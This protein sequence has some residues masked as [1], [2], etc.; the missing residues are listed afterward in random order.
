MIAISGPKGSG[1]DTVGQIIQQ[2]TPQ[3]RTIAYADPIKRV[4]QHLFDLNPENNDQ[5]DL[6][7]RTSVH[8]QLNGYLD[9]GVEGRHLV[10]E[11]GM[12][13]RSYDENQFTRYVEEQ[14]KLNPSKLWIVTDMRFNNELISLRKLNATIVQVVRPGYKFDG[15]A[16]ETG[17]S[18]DVFD[19]TIVNDGNM[20][21]LTRHVEDVL[22]DILLKWSC[23]ET[24]LGT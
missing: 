6:F 17:F 5:Y 19:Y 11:I 15:H 9:N 12:L 23:D 3:S 4:I 10:R 18:D 8:Y 1:K 7:K 20:D 21:D 24:H 2:L 16:T 14:I 13:M 22:D